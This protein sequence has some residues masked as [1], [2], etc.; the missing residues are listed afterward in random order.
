MKKHII[1]ILRNW[2]KII[3][4]IAGL[5]IA[6]LLI[7]IIFFDNDVDSGAIRQEINVYGTTLTGYSKEGG[8]QWEFKAE[9][10]ETEGNNYIAKKV[11]S[12]IIYRGQNAHVD[13]KAPRID[14]DMQS[15][16]FYAT[17]GVKILVLSTGQ[18]F[19]AD[20]LKWNSNDEIMRVDG[21]VVATDQNNIVTGK[22]LIYNVKEGKYEM[23]DGVRFEFDL[24]IQ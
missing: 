17:G 19:Q 13:I 1:K 10:I 4:G 15:Q 2:K 5:Y 18:E 22:N 3:L 8:K 24:E 20:N 21:K 9:E 14:I 16:N 6:Y 23:N 11:T 7:D 12:G